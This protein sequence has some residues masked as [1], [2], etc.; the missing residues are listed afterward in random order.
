MSWNW[1]EAEE[2]SQERARVEIKNSQA[3]NTFIKSRKKNASKA[4]DTCCGTW[5]PGVP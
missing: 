4:W 2:L 1:G 5:N 3:R